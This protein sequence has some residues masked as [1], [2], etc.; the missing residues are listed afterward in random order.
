MKTHSAKEKSFLKPY[1][2]WGKRNY[3]TLSPLFFLSHLRWGEEAEEP[4]W[5]PHPR[6]RDPQKTETEP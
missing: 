5:K 6:D 3:P 4:L 1:P 2:I